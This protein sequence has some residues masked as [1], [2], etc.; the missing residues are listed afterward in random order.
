MR[1]FIFLAVIF[2]FSLVASPWQV[3]PHLESL[4]NTGFEFDYWRLGLESVSS[5]KFK[6]GAT[7]LYRP[8][9]N[10]LTF[11]KGINDGARR[12]KKIQDLSKINKGTVAHEAFHAFFANHM[13]YD[14]EFQD[15]KEWFYARAQNLYWKF[16]ASKRLTAYEEAMAT[17]LGT[18]ITA[19][20]ESRSQIERA[21]ASE[22][23]QTC[24]RSL[25]LSQRFWEMHWNE[26]VYGYYYRNSVSEYWTDVAKNL[27]ERA[28]RKKHR[29]SGEDHIVFDYDQ[30]LTDVD[31]NWVAEVLL[32]GRMT[33][34]FEKT[35]EEDISMA[36]C[37]SLDLIDE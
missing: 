15:E 32:E 4:K 26:N 6:S 28:Q 37:E 27:W 11:E 23:Q 30:S 19:Y 1:S 24:L 18:T 29:R 35:F 14:K 2:P 22:D 5:V 10:Y 25:K 21:R 33:R 17:F 7:N 16:P 36:D 12:I 9:L 34:D 3:K 31:K 20:D 13:N 8:F